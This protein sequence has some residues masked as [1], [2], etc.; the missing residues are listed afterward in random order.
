[1]KA[2]ILLA[3]N[4][5]FGNTDCGRLPL[6]ALDLKRGWV[7][8]PRPKTA[9]ERRCKLWPETVSA[10]QEY[11]E[12]RPDPL[13]PE[14]NDLVFITRWGKPWSKGTAENPIYGEFKKL[15]LKLGLHRPQMGFYALRHGFETVAG[16]TADQVAVNSIMGHVDGTMAGV[17]R[18][19]ISDQRLEKVANFVRTW[20]FRGRGVK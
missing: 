12:D 11:L 8:F 13:N 3:A 6:S 14:H 9:I 17:Y 10:I 16:E 18:E 2:M 4:T 5:G 20:L 7:N 1:M 15:L 19:R